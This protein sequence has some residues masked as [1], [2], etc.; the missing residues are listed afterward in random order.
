MRLFVAVDVDSR[1]ESYLNNIQL[2]LD[3]AH[4]KLK[5]VSGY[6]ITLKFLGYVQDLEKVKQAMEEVRFN[7]FEMTTKGVGYFGK[8]NNIRVIWCG[9]EP[10]EKFNELHEKIDYELKK[11]GFAHDTKFHPHITL[12]RV[13][14]LY[15]KDGMIET[16]KNISKEEM[17]TKVNSIVLYK[18]TLTS[19]GPI[20]NV[21]HRVKAE[22]L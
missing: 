14:Q 17:T 2:E 21:V 9:V 7:S 1:I 19:Q 6:H 20:Y 22:D 10:K 13:K 8:G 15:N 3:T 5:P 12:A 11:I 16:L 4:A 18:S